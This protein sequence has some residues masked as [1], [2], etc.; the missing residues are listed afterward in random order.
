MLGM[1]QNFKSKEVLVKIALFL[2]VPI[3]VKLLVVLLVS[4][5][6]IADAVIVTVAQLN[7][8]LAH[9]VNLQH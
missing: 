3:L 6:K 7:F 2:H 4:I 5:P 8:K 9:K 1:R